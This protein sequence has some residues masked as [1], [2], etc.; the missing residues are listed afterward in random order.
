MA[1][2][3][4]KTVKLSTIMGRAGFV[5]GFAEARR[6]VPFDPEAFASDDRQVWSYER[7][8]LFGLIWSRPIKVGRRVDHEAQAAFAVA[9]ANGTIL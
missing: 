2:Y 6:G 9:L 1:N 4:S 5:R 8:R 7:G 3:T